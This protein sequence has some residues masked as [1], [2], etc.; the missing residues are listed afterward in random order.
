MAEG[1]FGLGLRIASAMA[2]RPRKRG[3]AL[4]GDEQVRRLLHIGGVSLSGLSS[5]LARMGRDGLPEF[6]SAEHIRRIN[7]ARLSRRSYLRSQRPR[8]PFLVKGAREPRV[9]TIRPSRFHELHQ[10]LKVPVDDGAGELDWQVANPSKL[11]AA[12]VANSRA[13]EQLYAETL[14]KHPP[15]V[16]RPWSVVVAF[17]EFIPGNKLQATLALCVDPVV[18][19][20]RADRARFCLGGPAASPL[21]QLYLVPRRR[22]RWPH[23]GS[24]NGA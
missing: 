20:D 15:S 3:K 4:P 7:L 18:V 14:T 23:V 17:D 11:L 2:D 21:T 10:V 12:L 9:C 6:H 1:V 13:L 8:A 22:R 16:E 24:R 19:V 5:L